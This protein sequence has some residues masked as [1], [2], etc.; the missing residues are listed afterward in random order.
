MKQ[1]ASQD[2]KVTL[3][4]GENQDTEEDQAPQGDPGQ[5]GLLVNMDQ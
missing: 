4:D 3:D 5:R 1:F 2:Q